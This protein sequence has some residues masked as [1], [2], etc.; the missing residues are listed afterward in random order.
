MPYLLER[1]DVDDV[2][3]L[4]AELRAL[5][6]SSGIDHESQALCR[7]LHSSLVDEGGEPAAALVRIYKTERF[8]RLPPDLQEFAASIG[9]DELPTGVRCLTLLGTAGDLPDWNDR[10][11]SEG[12]RAIPLPT[13]EFVERLPM[14]DQL[15]RQLGIEVRTVVEE[16]TQEEARQLAARANNVFHVENAVGSP[17]I[18]AQDF[19]EKHGIR[20]AVG[21]GGIMLS[22]DFFAAI[23]FS[24]VPISDPVART[25]KILAHP[26]RLRFLPF[27]AGVAARR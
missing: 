6:A 3:A 17:F 7:H 19:V 14:I 13:P 4:T 5:P 22:G 12:H 15:I 8:E 11:R 18:P 16:P 24:K 10:T 26:I 23:L 9:G 25:L 2:H 1:F 21:F 27:A 20:S